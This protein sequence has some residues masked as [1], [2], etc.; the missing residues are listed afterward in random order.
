MKYRG[1]F[2]NDEAPALTGW[3]HE[4]FGGFNHRFYEKVFELI[5]RLRATTC[6]PPCGATPST[7][8]TR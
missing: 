1:I 6:G 8:T 7:R 3:V 2:L 4:K 5:L